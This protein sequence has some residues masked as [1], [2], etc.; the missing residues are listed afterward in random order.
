MNN[1]DLHKC[2]HKPSPTCIVFQ[3][4]SV[5]YRLFQKGVSGKGRTTSLIGEENRPLGQR[6]MP[7]KKLSLSAV[8]A[9][10][11]GLR[12]VASSSAHRLSAVCP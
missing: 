9:D 5:T 2:L 4:L 6:G 7:S 12:I 1:K 11:G 8:Y 3:A 10:I